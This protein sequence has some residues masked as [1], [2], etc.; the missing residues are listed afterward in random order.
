M[1]DLKGFC[2]NILRPPGNVDSTHDKASEIQVHLWHSR[3]H[4][5]IQGI[6]TKPCVCEEISLCEMAL[7]V[8]LPLLE[9]KLI[10]TK[11]FWPSRVKIRFRL[12]RGRTN[13]FHALVC[14]DF[15]LSFLD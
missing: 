6:Q 11:L 9:V 13:V 5:L 8:K 2:N 3:E 4:N 10:E 12:Q 1:L 7:A 15:C 14:L